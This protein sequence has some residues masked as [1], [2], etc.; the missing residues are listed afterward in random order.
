MI[1]SKYKENHYLRMSWLSYRLHL[2]VLK[3]AV[4]RKTHTST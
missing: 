3:F 1:L 4:D 2:P